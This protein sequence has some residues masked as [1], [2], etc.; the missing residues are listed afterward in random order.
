MRPTTEEAQPTEQILVLKV[1][2]AVTEDMYQAVENEKKR[3]Q[4]PMRHGN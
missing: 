3:R 1:G 2:L 4:L